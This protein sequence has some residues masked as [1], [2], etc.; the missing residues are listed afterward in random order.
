DLK[1]LIS[2]VNPDS[3]KARDLCMLNPTFGEG[4]KLVGGADADLLIDDTLIDIKTTKSLELSRDTFNQLVGYYILFKVGGIDGA[5]FKL[6]IENLGIYYSRYGEL[7][8]FSIK[9]VMDEIKLSSF[10]EWFKK[11]ATDEYGK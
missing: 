4:S 5:P 11:R 9:M 2:I 3:F 10:I 6:G 1:K 7:Y 8:M